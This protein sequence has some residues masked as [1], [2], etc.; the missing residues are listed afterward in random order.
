MSGWSL[1]AGTGGPL[2]GQLLSQPSFYVGGFQA[3]IWTPL[4]CGRTEHGQPLTRSGQD[5]AGDRDYN[6]F[7]SPSLAPLIPSTPGESE[8]GIPTPQTHTQG[9][10]LWVFFGSGEL[11]FLLCTNSVCGWRRAGRQNVGSLD[12]RWPGISLCWEWR[13]RLPFCPQE[14][15][16][17]LSRLLP[18]EAE[19]G[20]A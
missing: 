12:R 7:P 10:G 2:G 6:L 14:R 3:E 4:S 9:S 19:V 17:S 1:L 18:R 16:F 5:Q 20:E 11:C 15:L 13:P 8:P